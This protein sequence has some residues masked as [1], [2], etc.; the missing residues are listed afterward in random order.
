MGTLA[1]APSLFDTLPGRPRKLSGSA[2]HGD[3]ES[4]GAAATMEV[5]RAVQAAGERTLDDLVVGAWEALAGHLS[6]RCLVCAG[7]VVPVYGARSAPVA[8]RCVACATELS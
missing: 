5:D 1:V 2:H 6:T 4:A 7:Q 8:G 3:L